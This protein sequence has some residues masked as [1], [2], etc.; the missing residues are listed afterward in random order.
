MY[1][2]NI[3]FGGIVEIITTFILIKKATSLRQQADICGKMEKIV[4]R[5]SQNHVTEYQEE[6]SFEVKR[7]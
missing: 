6:I 3:S 1:Q 4:L 7:F 2:I 5:D